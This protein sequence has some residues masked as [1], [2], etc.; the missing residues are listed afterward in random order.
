MSPTTS[1]SPKRLKLITG[2]LIGYNYDCDYENN[3]AY[4]N[5]KKAIIHSQGVERKLCEGAAT[6]RKGGS[7]R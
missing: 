5:A 4:Q 7:H 3:S 2:F 6:S 1:N